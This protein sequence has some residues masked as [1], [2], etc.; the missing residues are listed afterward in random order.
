MVANNISGTNRS[1]GPNYGGP[2]THYYISKPWARHER[3]S[4]QARALVADSAY[5]LPV[6]LDD[7]ELPG[8]PA[9]A[10]FGL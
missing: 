10:T 1:G 3:Q 9:T 4:A 5:V 6:R 2:D 8:L 7:A